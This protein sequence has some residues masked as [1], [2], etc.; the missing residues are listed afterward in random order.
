[1]TITPEVLQPIA[2]RL[3]DLLE[4]DRLPHALLLEGANAETRKEAAVQLARV[5]LCARLS[6]D[7]PGDEDAAMFGGM[8]LFGADTQEEDARLL[9]C[10]SCKHCR[11]TTAM[12]HPDFLFLEGDTA[13]R[14][15]HIDAI[16]QMRQ[17]ARL[18]PNE[19]RQKVIILHQAQSMTPEAQNAL[20]KL[21]E[22]PPDH[23]ALI[24]TAPARHM[25][26]ATVLSRVAV[27]SMGENC[28][29]ANNEQQTRVNET[30]Q[31][32]ANALAAGDA[33]TLL[34]LTAR[35]E[36]EKDKEFVRQC[37]AQT[38]CALHGQLRGEAH[39][40][41]REIILMQMERVRA[42]EV[43]MDRNPNQALLLSRFAAAIYR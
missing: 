30:A 21:L 10:E 17:D 32:I 24:L 41:R 13:A 19:A 28:E 9:P 31:S 20:L 5:L 37:F 8:S 16:R 18:L 3:T 29:E 23:T 40:S 7:A 35:L 6:D 14:S 27:F 36:K 15:F 42:L 39:E 38:R 22:E 26:L 33:Y 25:M 1:M 12:A 2:A 4:N 11:K 34:C 43:A